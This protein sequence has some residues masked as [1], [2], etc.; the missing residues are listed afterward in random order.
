ML[1]LLMLLLLLLSQCELVMKMPPLN[2]KKAGGLLTLH[3]MP[4]KV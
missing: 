1:L 2:K 3:P 4:S